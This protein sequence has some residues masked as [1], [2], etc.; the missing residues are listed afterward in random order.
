M[1]YDKTDLVVYLHDA[2]A[3]AELLHDELDGCEDPKLLEWAERQI[4]TAAGI[5][6]RVHMMMDS[7]GHRQDKTVKVVLH[8]L[9]ESQKETE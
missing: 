3:T 5:L 4:D 9:L 1:S 7:S 6:F 8:R 2:H